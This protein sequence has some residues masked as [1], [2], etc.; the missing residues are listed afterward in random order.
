MIV[1]R[2]EMEQALKNQVAK[3][4]IE[5]NVQFLGFKTHEEMNCYLPQSQALLIDTF[6]DN[7]MVS[8][9]EAIVSGTPILTN[10][11]P[12]N[13]SL[14]AQNKLG[15]VKDWNEDD[16]YILSSTSSYLKN[17]L[18]YRDMLSN[19]Y[20]ANALIEQYQQFYH[21]ISYSK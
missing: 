18:H 10:K 2:G 15:I 13:S 11:V 9:L 19:S 5:E 1:G 21:A 12:T 16:L 14:V 8:I 7:N 17:C 4:G 20:Q 3:L 6:R